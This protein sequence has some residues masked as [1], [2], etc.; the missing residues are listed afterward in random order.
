MDGTHRWY[1][2]NSNHDV[3]AFLEN[4]EHNGRVGTNMC[5]GHSRHLKD[6]IINLLLTHVMTYF[7]ATHRYYA[8]G[9]KDA[10]NG[11]IAPWL[12]G[13]ELTTPYEWQPADE[14]PYYYGRFVGVEYP[15]PFRLWGQVD[16]ATLYSMTAA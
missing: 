5:L 1:V 13:L 3:V 9:C 10:L 16:P 6:G 11:T 7:A 2:L 14:R 4:V 15:E 8:Y 12:E